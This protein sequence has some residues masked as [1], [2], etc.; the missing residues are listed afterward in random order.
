MTEKSKSGYMVWAVDN[1]VYGPAELPVLVQWV[2]EERITEDTWIYRVE[3]DSWIK[4]GDIGELESAFGKISDVSAESSQI[5]PEPSSDI[6]LRP[7]ML[8]QI[9]I[10]AALD[11]EKLKF[12]LRYLEPQ[13]IK[14]WSTIVKQNDPGDGMYMVLEGEVRVRIMVNG[15]ESTLATLG[16][17]DFFGEFCL[18]DHGPRSADVIANTDCLLLKL[19][20]SAFQDIVKKSPE[21]ATPFMH[22]LCKTLAARIRSDNKRF[23]QFMQFSRL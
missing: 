19:S 7:G 2:S 10:F 18:C 22:S 8:R 4:A 13:E 5:T 3:K 14:Q 23:S 20:A 11:D 6:T 15:K 1:V 17:G 9:K 12:F 16:V 21:T